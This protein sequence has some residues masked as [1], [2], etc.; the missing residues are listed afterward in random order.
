L[1]GDTFNLA[2]IRRIYELKGRPGDNPLIAHVL[3]AGWLDR[4]VDR[5]DDR[6]EALAARFWPGPLTIVVT[7]STQVLDEATAGLPTIAVRS[8]AH[9]VARR[10]LQ[11][12]GGPISA[13][14]ANRSGRVSPSRAEHVAADFIDVDDLLILDAG[15]TS[16]GIESTVVDLSGN[17]SRVLRPGS[18]TRQQLESVLGPI[19]TPWIEAQASAPGTSLRH[20][21]PRKPAELMSGSELPARLSTLRDPAAVLCFDARDVP[22]PHRA[23]VMPRQADAYAAALYTALREADSLAVTRI[24]IESPP[25]RSGVWS[26]IVDRLRRA[27][28]QS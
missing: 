28:T 26:A 12:F 7:K 23:L 5:W 17:V 16:V 4:L 10:L 2:A 18:I 27:T 15:P 13:P 11:A 19:E 3:D 14:S 21:A 22:A 25:Y 9:E 8:P 6:C 24:L 1:G 20:Y